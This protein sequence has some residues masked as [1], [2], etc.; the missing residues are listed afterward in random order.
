MVE[1]SKSNSDTIFDK[2]IRR[3]VPAQILFEDDKCIV[4]NDLKPVAPVHFLVVAK[5]LENA[6]KL[7]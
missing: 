4:V 1:H 6:R 3:E 7:S 2:I 5:N